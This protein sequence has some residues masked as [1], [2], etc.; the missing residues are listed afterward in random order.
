V[1]EALFADWLSDH[2]VLIR[3]ITGKNIIVV[4]ESIARLYP[5]YE[6]RRGL[7]SLLVSSIFPTPGLIDDIRSL[8]TGINTEPESSNKIE[9]SPGKEI[10]VPVDYSG[11]DLAELVD[12]LQMSR[13]E[14][15]ARHT[16]TPWIVHMLGF[17]PGFPYLT[18]LSED[19][20]FDLPRRKTPRT[21]VPAGS[22][23]IAAGLSC[24][25]PSEMPGGWWL[26]GVTNLTLFEPE[27]NPPAIF[28]PGDRVRFME[29]G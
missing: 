9:P 23:G 21:K 26:L 14:I 11:S 29:V 16:G 7:D 15:I 4:E 17:A 5:L 8:L 2:S 19:D 25:Y 6:V 28:A 20:V 18:N 22:V 24:I 27:S 13:E 3:G 10:I 12:K 1:E